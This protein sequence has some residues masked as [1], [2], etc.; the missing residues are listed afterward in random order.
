MDD[1]VADG[2]GGEIE[3][4]GL[5]VIAIVKRKVN[6]KFGARVEEALTFGIFADAVEEGGFGNA[7]DDEIPGLAVIAGA[8]EIGM[9][10][11]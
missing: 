1:N 8:I 7:I 10:V 6:A 4:E 2:S 3:L 9:A 5:P 11:V